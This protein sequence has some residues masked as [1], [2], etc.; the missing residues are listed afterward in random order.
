M[1]NAEKSRQLL[2]VINLILT[3]L[4][5]IGVIVVAGWLLMM[6]Q[7]INEL[8]AA[9]GEMAIQ[10]T[11]QSTLAA[12]E[13]EIAEAPQEQEAALEPTEIIEAPTAEATL[14]NTATPKPNELTE[15]YFN[16]IELIP[17]P[18]LNELS[19]KHYFRLPPLTFAF[20]EGWDYRFNTAGKLTVLD[21]FGHETMM[22]ILASNTRKEFVL[23]DIG[24][25]ELLSDGTLSWFPDTTPRQGLGAGQYQLWLE[26]DEYASAPIAI[27]LDDAPMARILEAVSMYRT[28]DDLIQ[29]RRYLSFASQ[30]EPMAMYG[31]MLQDDGSLYIRVWRSHDKYYYWVK[32]DHVMHPDLGILYNGIE[33]L[34]NDE[35]A[36]I[37]PLIEIPAQ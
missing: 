24:A 30:Q 8:S 4:I 27:T 6:E 10:L 3:A 22:T 23:N 26:I 20:P 11:L 13:A 5:L 14:A 28:Y 1:Q 21:A 19:D 12:Y 36:E 34:L 9:S 16:Q 33:D 25:F 32:G 17:S 15:A 2:T 37:I 35:G 7:R 18:M 29:D 31:Y